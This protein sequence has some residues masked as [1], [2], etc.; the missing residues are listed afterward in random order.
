M[1]NR[2][3]HELLPYYGVVFYAQGIPEPP[4][5]DHHPVVLGRRRHVGDCLLY[6]A[7]TT[8]GKAMQSTFLNG[9]VKLLEESITDSVDVVN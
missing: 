6:P 5:D 7:T 1:Q 8:H 9:L 4:E 3:M 2:L